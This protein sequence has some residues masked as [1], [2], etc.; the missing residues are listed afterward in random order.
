MELTSDLG[1]DSGEGPTA[2]NL[3]EI[4]GDQTQGKG[5]SLGFISCKFGAVTNSSEHFGTH[6]AAWRVRQKRAESMGCSTSSS[7]A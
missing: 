4:D 3:H 6:F 1:E 5:E 7:V 2:R